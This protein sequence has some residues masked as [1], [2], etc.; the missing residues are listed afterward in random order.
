MR[1]RSLPCSSPRASLLRSLNAI[2]LLP[3]SDFVLLRSPC[4]VLLRPSGSE[5]ISGAMPELGY[6]AD[7]SVQRQHVVLLCRC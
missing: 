4:A 6:G 2:L 3:Q 5:M 7:L 1:S